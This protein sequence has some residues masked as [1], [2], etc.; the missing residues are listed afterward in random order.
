M[1]F[2]YIAIGG[3]FATALWLGRGYSAFVDRRIGELRGFSALILHMEGEISRTLG[4][5]PSLFRSFSD[6]F[7]EK[8]GLLPSLR[9][10]ISL[11]DAF[12][13]CRGRLALTKEMK[14]MLSSLFSSFGRGYMEEEISR[15]REARGQIELALGSE[16][17]CLEKNKKVVNALLFG[18]AASGAIILM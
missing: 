12:L 1:I 16:C 7:L 2:R 18:A 10:G 11:E 8:C 3:L 4:F 15:L 13:E 6:E 17:E 9:Q 14:D 5:G